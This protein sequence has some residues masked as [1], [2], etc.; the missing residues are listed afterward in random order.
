MGA[1]PLYPK[2][3]PHLPGNVLYLNRFLLYEGENESETKP[4]PKRDDVSN[5]F[6]KSFNQRTYSYIVRLYTE[7]G[8]SLSSLGYTH[9]YSNHLDFIITLKY[10]PR[11][12]SVPVYVAEPPNIY[13]GRNVCYVAIDLLAIWKYIFIPSL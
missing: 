1:K 5:Q 2:A 9:G 12:A 4:R 10:H 3:S 8:W 13:T 7:A 11:C 6:L